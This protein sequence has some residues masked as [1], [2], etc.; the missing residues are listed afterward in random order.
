MRPTRQNLGVLAT[1]EDGADDVPVQGAFHSRQLAEGVGETR[2][3]ENLVA[4]VPEGSDSVEHGE[5]DEI[6]M[7]IVPFDGSRAAP[8]QD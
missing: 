7:H 5:V 6:K 8:G 3:V 4:L 2:A 1:A